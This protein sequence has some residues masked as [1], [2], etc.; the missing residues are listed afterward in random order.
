MFLSGPAQPKGKL[1]PTGRESFPHDSDSECSASLIGLLTYTI[2]PC[3]PSP[4]ASRCQLTP[5]TP[6]PLADELTPRLRC[7]PRRSLRVPPP[8]P[9]AHAPG[10]PAPSR[11]TPPPPPARAPG[12]AHPQVRALPPPPLLFPH[13]PQTARVPPPPLL[14]VRP[15]GI[16]PPHPSHDRAV[17]SHC[18][19][20]PPLTKLSAESPP[21]EGGLAPYFFDSFSHPPGTE[22][23]QL[24]IIYRIKGS[25]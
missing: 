4:L 16:P 19:V 3:T 18:Q 1:F 6:S 24:I 23:Y 5:P 20:R 8:P 2:L 15:P 21:P 11:P 25:L 7:A 13:P 14:V 22:A 17:T 9:V 12:F 10:A